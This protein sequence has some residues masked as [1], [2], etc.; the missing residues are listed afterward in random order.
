[1]CL[2]ICYQPMLVDWQLYLVGSAIWSIFIMRR[3]AKCD[4]CCRRVSV[5]LFVC[6]CLSVTL[7]YCT[8]TDKRS[9]RISTDK[10][11]ARSL[12]HSR[13]TCISDSGRISMAI[14]ISPFPIRSTMRVDYCRTAWTLQYV[15]IF[16]VALISRYKLHLNWAKFGPERRSIGQD[17]VK[18]FLGGSTFWLTL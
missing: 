9:C 12:C 2:A 18:G 3:Y 10:R 15:Q 4:T 7:R 6:L 13:A 14:R 5:R 11:V 8:K 17:I 1:M 16:S